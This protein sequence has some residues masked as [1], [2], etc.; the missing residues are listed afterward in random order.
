M[1]EGVSPE[2]TFW[3]HI[4]ELRSRLIKIILGVAIGGSVA[5]FYWEKIWS[6]VAY[7]L[8]K[9]HLKVDFI[10]TSPMETFL[11]SLKMSL[12]SGIIVSLPWTLWQVWRFVAPAL[13]KNEKSIFVISFLASILMFAGGSLF[14]YFFVLPEG[15][16]FLATYTN[17][18]ITQNW[19]QAEFTSFISQ[20]MLAFGIIFEL[21]VGAYVLSK[22]G[23][24]TAKGMWGFFRYA[25]VVIFIVAAVLTPGPDPVS[26]LMLAIPLC[27][28]YAVSIGICALAE[29]KQ[30]ESE[31]AA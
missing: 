6:L 16:A 2:L 30:R 19:K 26:Q 11:T 3:D 25:I 31:E 23:L 15:L 13:F 9:Q 29:K 5:Y 22:L 28:L 18:A 21:P 14:S 12:I 27:F 20:F 4:Q 17:G 7:P 10:A 8:T 24:I 1:P